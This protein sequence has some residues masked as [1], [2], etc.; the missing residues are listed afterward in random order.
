[1]A[2]TTKREMTLKELQELHRLL[3]KFYVAYLALTKDIYES[4][5]AWKARF[6]FDD[7]CDFVVI[8]E[9]EQENK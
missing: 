5:V 7:V 1:M 9:N 2:E 6:A 3:D 4:D 8:K